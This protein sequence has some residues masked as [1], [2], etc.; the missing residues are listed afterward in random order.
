MVQVLALQGPFLHAYTLYILH[1]LVVFLNKI[2]T[3][4]FFLRSSLFFV[5]VMAVFS[6]MLK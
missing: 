5:S 6:F 3:L 4:F 2:L 1:Q